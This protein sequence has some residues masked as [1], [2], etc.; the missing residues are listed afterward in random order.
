MDQQGNSL[1]AFIESNFPEKFP[2]RNVSGIENIRAIYHY[3]S[4]EVFEKMLHDESDF[5]LSESSLLN[6]RKELLAGID[7]LF[8]YQK[9]IGMDLFCGLKKRICKRVC[10]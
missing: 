3:T 2:Q 4:V 8:T 5:Y 9:G 1:D 7:L 10:E 6:D